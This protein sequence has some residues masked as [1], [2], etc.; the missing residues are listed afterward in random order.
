MNDPAFKLTDIIWH[1]I[2]GYSSNTYSL[3]YVTNELIKYM[4]SR[5]CPTELVDCK[6]RDYKIVKVCDHQFRIVRIHEW[7]SYDIRAID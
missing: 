4:T 5:G 1:F 7:N 3:P 6:H 2:R